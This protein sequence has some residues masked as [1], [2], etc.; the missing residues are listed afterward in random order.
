[1]PDVKHMLKQHKLR[2]T[3]GRAAILQILAEHEGALSER[4]IEDAIGQRCDRVTIYRTL[5]TFL[6]HGLIHRVLDDSG[7]MK[8]ASCTPQCHEGRDHA[9]DHVHF[10]CIKCGHTS[11]LDKVPIPAVML[12]QGY[13]LQEVNMLL[14]GH[15]P[16]CRD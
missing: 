10:K 14:Q 13:R 5:S 7:A 3:Q 2:Y 9:H 6:D 4:D 15:C 11:C 1:M 8:Y 12:P 16:A